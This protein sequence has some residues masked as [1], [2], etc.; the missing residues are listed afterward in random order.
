[1]TLA[2]RADSSENA[3][4]AREQSLKY[5][6]RGVGFRDVRPRQRGLAR[7]GAAEPD[8]HAGRVRPE[9]RSHLL[10]HRER[11]LPAH[12]LQRPDELD[13]AVEVAF[14]AGSAVDALA[15]AVRL[16]EGRFR[17]HVFH[18]E[19]EKF[20]SGIIDARPS[21]VRLKA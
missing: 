15:L 17:R 2:G 5:E 21:P 3:R 7:A 20:R 14:R 11:G 1:M 6:L 12:L 8:A 16:F 13:A 10:R 9:E 4:R 19:E 18:S